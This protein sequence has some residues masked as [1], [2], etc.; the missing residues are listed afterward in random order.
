MGTLVIEG[1]NAHLKTKEEQL[2]P[3][4]EPGEQNVTRQRSQARVGNDRI[5]EL[6]RVPASQL[7]PHPENWRIHPQSQHTA[8]QGVLEQVG[9]ADAVLAYEP[10]PGELVLIDG[11]LR[12]ETLGDTVVPVLVTD[13]TE[14]E[15]RIILATH[16]P[17]AEM[18]VQDDELMRDLLNGLTVEDTRVQDLI[19]NLLEDSFEWNPDLSSVENVTPG[20]VALQG[21]ITIKA[22]QEQIPD[23]R[24]AIDQA[25]TDFNDVTI[26]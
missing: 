5:K 7:Q 23:I 26:V 6:R 18:A 14:A 25:L 16:D 8:L 19:D 2:M 21:T 20:N 11:H 22:S 12:R 3:A 24:Q 15:A 4:K 13:L 9:I 17:L 1:I 10:S